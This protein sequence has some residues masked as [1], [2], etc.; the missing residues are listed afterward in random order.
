[1]CTD[2]CEW[3]CMGAHVCIGTQG[4][5]G[6]TKTMHADTKTVVQA[7]IWALWPGKVP[8]ASCVVKKKQK[9]HGRL[10]LGEY[11]FAWVQWYVF[12]RGDKK[13]RENE[14]KNGVVRTYFACVF[15]TK[16]N[17]SFAGVIKTVI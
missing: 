10:R 7:L 4:T 13:T 12:A 1:M 16:K 9:W 3:V 14:A 8:R 17:M 15:M 2:R 11:G 5:R 6:G